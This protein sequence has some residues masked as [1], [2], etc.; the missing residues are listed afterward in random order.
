MYPYP[1]QQLKKKD[2]EKN[3]TVILNL[4]HIMV[5]ITNYFLDIN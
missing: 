1:A 5:S 4:N 3:L 2:M